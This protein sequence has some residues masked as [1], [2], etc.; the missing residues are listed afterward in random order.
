MLVVISVVI[1][2]DA[3]MFLWLVAVLV[4]LTRVMVNYEIY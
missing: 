1:A 4:T 2:V 3:V